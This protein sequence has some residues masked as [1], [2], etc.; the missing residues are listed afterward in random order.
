LSSRTSYSTAFYPKQNNRNSVEKT[1]DNLKNGKN[2]FGQTTYD[3]F[4]KNP[5]PED[6][7]P[8]VR[9][10]EKLDKSPHYKHQFCTY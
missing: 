10:N 5:N 4:Y 3:R 9:N 8:R 6:Y 1:P 2:W 7:L